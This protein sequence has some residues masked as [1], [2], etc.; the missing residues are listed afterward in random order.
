MRR[1]LFPKPPKGAKESSANEGPTPD[2]L[3]K[4]LFAGEIGSMK[5]GP[6]VGDKAPEFSLKTSDGKQTIGLK[7]RLGDKP[8]VLVFGNFSCGPFRSWSETIAELA[9]THKSRANFLGIYIREAH[10]TDGW[11]MESNDRADIAFPQPTD[12]AGR[13]A[14]AH[15]ARGCSRCRSRCSWTRW[16][17]MPATLTAECRRG[18]TSSTRMAS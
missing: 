3:I 10:P 13:T 17:T 12:L 5:E 16:T 2:T 7:D 15:D 9:E 14:V 1:L 8:L 11:R 18:S 4:G 6:K